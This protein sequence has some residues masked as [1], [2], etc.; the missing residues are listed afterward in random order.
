LL[1]YGVNAIGLSAI[2]PSLLAAMARFANAA[3]ALCTTKKG[4]I[5]AMPTRE[6]VRRAMGEGD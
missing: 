3:G 1:H 6:E 5:P 2:G 4:A